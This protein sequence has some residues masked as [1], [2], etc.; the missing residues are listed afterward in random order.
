MQAFAQLFTALDQTNKTTVKVAALKQYF[1]EAPPED[2]VW[3]LALF[4]HR[5]P[6]RQINTSLLRTWAAE[7]AKV[8]TWLFEES[9]H[10]VGDLAETM[11]LLLPPPSRRQ[12]QSLSYWIAQLQQVGPLDEEAKKTFILDAWDRM[13]TPERF[14]FTKLL[15]GSFR[16]GVSQ[17]LV[18]RA[19]A[20]AYHLEATQVTHRIMGQWDPATTP[21]RNLLLEEDATEDL[22]RPYPFHLAHP[23]EGDPEQ[24]G[25]IRDWQAEWKW[26]GIRGQVI[27]RDG[28]FFIWTRGEELVTEKF[29][30]LHTLKDWL[31][32]GTVVDGEILPFRD[33]QP[34]PFGVLQTRIGRKNITKKA[35]AEAPVVLLAYDVLEWEGQD[36]RKQPTATRRGYLDALVAHLDCPPEFR[37]SPLLPAD[38]WATWANERKRAREEFAEGL[39]LKHKKAPYA[40]GR[41]R[42]AWWKWKMEPLT[43]DGVLVYAQRGHGRRA[44]LYTDY[45]FAVWKG[46]E[47]VPFTK[48]YSGLTDRELV[49]VDRFVKR[50]TRERFGPVRTVTPELVME[51]AFEGIQQSKRHKSGVALRF[52]RIH[53]WRLDKTVAQANTLEDLQALLEV[54]GAPPSG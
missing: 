53:R 26:D 20:E 45:T 54:Y 14:V 6:R 31:P 33:G 48:A 32:P 28:E 43:I 36:V 49:E 37:A 41:V 15:T 42:G 27:A 11:A 1:T 10:V 46:D 5:R 3:A 17:Q 22:S 23:L 18:V 52:P 40:T 44:N 30:E 35:L 38:R 21:F 4:T 9:Y 34:L 13:S 47:L 7:R 8:P 25:D 50:N 19:L 2:R 39:M 29:P 51:I 24:L 12:Q 16:V